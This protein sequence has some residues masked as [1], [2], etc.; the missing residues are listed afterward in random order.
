MTEVSQSNS[1][2]THRSRGGDEEDTAIRVGIERRQSRLEQKETALHI[3]RPA[4]VE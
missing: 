2:A 4:L 1:W 3:A